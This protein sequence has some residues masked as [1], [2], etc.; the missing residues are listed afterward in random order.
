MNRLAQPLWS[1]PSP[2]G[3]PDTAAN[4][5]GPEALLARVDWCYALAGRFS[6]NDAQE[7]AE[8]VLG[9]LGRDTLRREIG[10]AGSAQDALTILLASPEFQRR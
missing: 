6:R 7:A 2:K 4:W 5:A 1:P 10:R 8:A 3:W 9:R